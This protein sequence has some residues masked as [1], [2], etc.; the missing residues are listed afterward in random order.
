MCASIGVDLAFL[1]FA[2][3]G[4]DE[5]IIAMLTDALDRRAVATS[6]RR[7]FEELCRPRS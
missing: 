7:H 1:H 6:V 5:A 3:F 2:D 4:R